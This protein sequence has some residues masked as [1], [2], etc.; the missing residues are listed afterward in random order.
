[1]RRA[2][3]LL[4]LL[5]GCDKVRA[6]PGVQ[7]RSALGPPPPPPV[8]MGPWILDPEPTEAT[9]CWVTD[10]PSTGRVWYGTSST[11]HLAREDGQP[12]TDHRVV[13]HRLQPATQ[14]RYAI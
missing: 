13:V 8:A 5:A 14:Y 10:E 12:R 3:I 4:A 2:F 1:M 9:V 7:P 11:D 6:I